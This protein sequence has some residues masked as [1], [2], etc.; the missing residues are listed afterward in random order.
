MIVTNAIKF[1]ATRNDGRYENKYSER[2]NYRDAEESI[3]SAQLFQTSLRF[4][5]EQKG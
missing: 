2:I 5:E 3:H 4:S 1:A